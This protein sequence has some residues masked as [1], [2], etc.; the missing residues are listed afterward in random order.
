[1]AEPLKLDSQTPLA[2]QLVASCLRLGQMLQRSQVPFTLIDHSNLER[3][4]V[5]DDG[6]LAIGGRMYRSLVLPQGVQLPKPAAAIVAQ[7][8]QTGGL[9]LRDGV[10]DATK[11]PE[12]LTAVLHPPARIQPA[13]PQIALGRFTRNGRDIIAVVNVGK[14]AYQ[15]Q[16]AIQTSGDWLSLDPATGAIDHA[17][18]SDG[19]IVLHLN[20]RQTLI[21]VDSGTPAVP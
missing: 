21:L 9:V 16:V 19:S 6:R 1:M 3:A 17:A 18:S 10:A 8:T 5:Q 7:F 14:Q 12:A 11:S 4:V 15:G 20:P 2:Q 13:S